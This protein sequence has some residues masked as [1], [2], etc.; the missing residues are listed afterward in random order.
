MLADRPR[1]SRRFII[2]GAMQGVVKIKLIGRITDL[3]L[4]FSAH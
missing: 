2:T 1:A 3:N 4:I